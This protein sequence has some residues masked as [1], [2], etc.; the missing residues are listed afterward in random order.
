MKR[1]VL[2]EEIKAPEAT[3]KSNC[4]V[5]AVPEGRRKRRVSKALLNLGRREWLISFA[6]A[7]ERVC[8]LL[9]S[10]SHSHSEEM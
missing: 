2:R 6:R 8:G 3:E 10:S 1:P 4:L 7:M 5:P 9:A